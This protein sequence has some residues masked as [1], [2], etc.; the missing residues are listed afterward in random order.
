MHSVIKCV[1]GEGWVL[2]E[3]YSQTTCLP[4]W[5]GKLGKVKRENVK[6]KDRELE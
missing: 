2:G 4:S 3:N 5:R 1:G 6:I